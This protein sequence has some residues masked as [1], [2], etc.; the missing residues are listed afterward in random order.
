MS[1]ADVQLAKDV[2][3]LTETENYKGLITELESLYQPARQHE[4]IHDALRCILVTMKAL[5]PKSV[6]ALKEAEAAVKAA[7]SN[8]A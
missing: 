4:N 7:E 1:Q 2:A 5:A 3:A 8:E 6:T